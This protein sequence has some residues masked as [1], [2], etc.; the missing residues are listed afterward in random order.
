VIAHL[1][2]FRPKGDLTDSQR[3]AV[4]SALEAALTGIPA[5]RR[6]RVGRR[7]TLGRPYDAYNAEDYPFVAMLEFDS[8]T[9]LVAYLEHPA[10]RSLGEQFY[11]TSDRALAMDFELLEDHQL[12]QLLS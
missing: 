12:R 9:D 2:L 6:A 10:H 4:V 1:V 3:H 7:R 5:I 11:L 8:E